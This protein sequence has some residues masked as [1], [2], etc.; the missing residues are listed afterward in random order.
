M[1][2]S[3]MLVLRVCNPMAPSIDLDQGQRAKMA[4]ITKCL[5]MVHELAFRHPQLSDASS[6]Q[7]GRMAVT[8]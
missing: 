6:K 5:Q 8:A 4:V 7:P 1:I 2:K 3:D